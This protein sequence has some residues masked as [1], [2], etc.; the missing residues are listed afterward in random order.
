[1]HTD[2]NQPDAVARALRVLAATAAA[3]P[4][5][6]EEFERRAQQHRRAHRHRSVGAVAALAAVA[7]LSTVVLCLRW[8]AAP[9]FAQRTALSGAEAREA[10]NA[11]PA[12][13]PALVHVGTHAA[14]LGLEDRIAQV[15]D[16]LS[17]AGAARAP[18]AGLHALQQERNRLAGALM[19]VRY[20]ETL[21]DASQ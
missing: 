20:A 3:E 10:W 14:V 6:F 17:A 13:E 11:T 15:D 9:T 12:H 18:P 1:M 2:L 4:Y 7:V 19:Q 5:G 16:L 21:V 8:H